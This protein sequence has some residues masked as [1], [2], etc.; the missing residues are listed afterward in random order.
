MYFF[1]TILNRANWLAYHFFPPPHGYWKWQIERLRIIISGHGRRSKELSSD[2]LE[3]I[4]NKPTT[5]NRQRIEEG[6]LREEY[7]H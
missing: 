6:Q 5:T 2:H 3:E 7:G 1:L 4:E